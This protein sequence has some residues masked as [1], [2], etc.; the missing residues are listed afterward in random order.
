M[1][2]SPDYKAFVL[3]LLTAIYPVT[4]RH[5]F[6]GVGIYAGDVMCALISSEDELYFKADD[7][8]RSDYE[9]LGAEQ[10]HSMPYFALPAEVLEDDEALESWLNKSIEAAKRMGKLKKKRGRT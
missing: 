2:T 1:A 4:S 6:G 7:E 10:F 5:M 3:E 9:A 8:N